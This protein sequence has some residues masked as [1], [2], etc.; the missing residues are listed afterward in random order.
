M[1]GT[2]VST[3]ARFCRDAWSAPPNRAASR[4]CLSV[5]ALGRRLKP[6]P[7]VDGPREPSMAEVDPCANLKP[8]DDLLEWWKAN[9]SNICRGNQLTAKKYDDIAK[10]IA[11][12]RRQLCHILT[13]RNMLERRDAPDIDELRRLH[14]DLTQKFVAAQDI[15]ELRGDAERELDRLLAG[16]GEGGIAV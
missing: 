11:G 8:L 13:L 12:Y 14:P 2:T 16:S 5:A 6:N 9:R 7:N 15:Y 10:Q 3:A 4:T 1:V